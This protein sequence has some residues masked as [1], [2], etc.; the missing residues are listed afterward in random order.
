M[1]DPWLT[2]AET[3]TDVLGEDFDPDLIRLGVAVSRGLLIDVL[4][5]DSA[6]AAT[7]SME[8]FVAMWS[9]AAETA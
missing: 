9:S 1:T 8:H 3:A 4:A 2:V 6:D 5:T 7:R